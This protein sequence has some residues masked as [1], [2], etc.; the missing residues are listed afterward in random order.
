MSVANDI[1]HLEDFAGTGITPPSSRDPIFT[2]EVDDLESAFGGSTNS[3]AESVLQ[4]PQYGQWLDEAAERS[5]ERARLLSLRDGERDS[6]R[7]WAA[8]E[9]Q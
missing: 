1:A 7:E 6:E 2:S 4:G 3:L 8:I 5:D 9:M